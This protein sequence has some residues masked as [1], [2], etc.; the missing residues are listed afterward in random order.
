MSFVALL[1]ILGFLLITVFAISIFWNFNKRKQ[2]ITLLEIVL[3]LFSV[4]FFMT[5]FL[6]QHSLKVLEKVEYGNY[7]EI[8]PYGDYIGG[9]LNPLIALFAVVAAGFAFYA[10]YQANKQVQEQFKIQQFESRLYKMIDIYNLNVSNLKYIGRK[11]GNAF[12]G[13]RVFSQLISNFSK[14]KQEILYFNKK[15]HINL[16]VMITET[17]K[18]HLISLKNDVEINNWIALELSYILFFYGVGI[19]GRKS[20]KSI[21]KDKYHETYLR[22]LLNY[23]SNKPTEY[24]TGIEIQAGWEL[25][26]V[27]FEDFQSPNNKKFDKY[28]NGHQNNLGHYYRHIF[29]VVKFISEQDYL[30]YLEKWEYSKLLR[31]QLS[32]HEQ[33]LFFINSISVLGREWELNQVKNQNK[34]NITKFDLIKNISKAVRDKHKIEQFYPH[35]EFEDNPNRTDYRGYLEK[36]VYR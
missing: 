28:Y 22:P 35:V 2:I 32:N 9:V 1:F 13:K 36:E 12:E 30:S 15:K 34:K 5:A 27:N 33:E 20:I 29:M 3:F 25:I 4:F 8:G 24:N 6:L 11:S 18:T 21:L 14:L 26:M 31:T 7:G 19:N 17:Y 16:E 23:L 10:Q